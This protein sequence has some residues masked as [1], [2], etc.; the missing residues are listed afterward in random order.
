MWMG[1][2]HLGK[3]L[4]FLEKKTLEVMKGNNGTNIISWY[5]C[6]NYHRTSPKS[7]FTIRTK[8]SK[9]DVLQTKTFPDSG[10]SVKDNDSSDYHMFPFIW[11]ANV[12]VMAPLFMHLSITF[13]N[14]SFSNCSPTMDVGDVM[15]KSCGKKVLKANRA[16]S[17]A[18]THAAV[19]P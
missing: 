2:C 12:M 15:L 3:L 13:S 19:V 8:P 6:S 14:Q 4:S 1:C 11:Y 18:V 17:S 9:F 7:C 16:F 10:K 5:C